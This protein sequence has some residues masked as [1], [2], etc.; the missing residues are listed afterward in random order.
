MISSQVYYKSSRDF[1]RASTLL[2]ITFTTVFFPRLLDILGAPEIVNFAHFVIVPLVCLWVLAKSQTTDRTQI[3]VTW[4]LIFSLLTFLTAIITSALINQAGVINVILEFIL[5]AESFVLL[6]AVTS[7]TISI[8]RIKLLQ[9]WMGIFALVNFLFVCF[10]YFILRESN[11]DKLF[12]IFFSVAGATVSSLVSITFALYYLTCKQDIALW[13]RALV[14]LTAIGQLLISDTKL[15]LGSFILGFLLLSFTKLNRRTL[16]YM[17]FGFL[18]V[19]G[20]SWAMYNVPY[21]TN[22]SYWIKPE[23][24]SSDNEFTRAKGMAIGIIPSLYRNSLDW[25]FGL[26]PGHGISRLGGWMMDKYWYLLQPLGGTHPYPT[27][28]KDI[29]AAAFHESRGVAGT[30]MF[31][32]LFAW[33]GIWSDLGLLGLAAYLSIWG[34]IWQKICL[35][36]FSRLLV[37]SQVGIGFFPGYLEEPGSMLF[38]TFILGLRWLELRQMSKS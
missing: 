19:W 26:G 30:A 9:S 22:Y 28:V 2:L 17:I 4:A 12:G 13:I 16:I 35:D 31:A 14:M 37:L 10:Q 6:V 34:V 3:R 25:L 18:I 32:P 36:D 33:A 27:L 7:L 29:T 15:V 24:F 23:Y 20:F 5:L 38:I 11:P 8:D 21:F 1:I